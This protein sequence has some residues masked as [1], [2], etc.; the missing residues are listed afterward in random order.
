MKQFKLALVLATF[1]AGALPAQ[2]S[3]SV[4]AARWLSGCW[5]L[6]A[7]NRLT[8]E[9][10]MPAA[11]DL[12][13]GASRTI[14]GGVVREFEQ[15]R[16]RSDAGK[17]VYT[18]LPS[19][20]R[21]ASFTSTLVSDT[22]I[23]FE[24]PQHDFPQK[25]IYRKRGADSLHAR[26]EGPGPNGPRGF[27]LAMARASC[28]ESSAI[29]AGPPPAP[30]DTMLM[31]AQLSPDGKQL[32][33]SRGLPNNLDIFLALPNGQLVKQLTSETSV[34]Y[35]PAWSPDG[36]RI[37]FVS[38]R[39][40]LQQIFLMQADGSNVLQLTNAP[41]ENTDADWSPDGRL[42]VFRSTREGFGNIYLMNAD[43]SNQRA[44][45]S[46]S[47]NDLSPT[48]SPDGRRILFSSAR[49]GHSDLFVMNVDGSA[50]TQLSTTTQ[51]HTGAGHWSPDGKRIAFWSTRDGNADVYVMNADG[52]NAQNLTRDT[53]SDVPQGWSP[54]GSVIYFRSTRDRRMADLYSMKPDGTGV[55]RITTTR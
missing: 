25:I 46:D 38:V 4:A 17:L 31:D 19:G 28:T 20:Q 32:V 12:M 5:E 2:Q 49:A 11:G 8:L 30:P 9:M 29:P 52:T 3:G 26:V 23:V 35:K 44:L 1:S 42:I 41:G 21:E 34:D 51:G 37:A 36:R 14:M 18:A 22:A 16:I 43:G 15:L 24:N 33:V 10:W 40:R 48:F 53:A 45:T 7:N 27:N 54:D 50:T 6:R 55:S 39:D 47:A 13:L